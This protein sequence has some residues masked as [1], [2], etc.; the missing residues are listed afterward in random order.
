MDAT[1]ALGVGENSVP[2]CCGKRVLWVSVVQQ[3]PRNMR[4][5]IS[6]GL[7]PLAVFLLSIPLYATFVFVY[8][9]FVYVTLE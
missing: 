7:I 5:S 4:L 1:G 8:L 6:R 9:V 3:L 2:G